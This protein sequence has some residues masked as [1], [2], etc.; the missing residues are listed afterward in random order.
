MDSF[1]NSFIYPFIHSSGGGQE[2]FAP[3]Y[4][5][6]HSF[7]WITFSGRSEEE[8]LAHL[9]SVREAAKRGG[10][11]WAH[12]RACFLLGRLC[13]R[14]LKYSQVRVDFPSFLRVCCQCQR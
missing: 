2:D 6:Q 8:L 1:I 12:R 3:L 11:R 9:E 14:K 4:D 5:L 13:A 10:R 7:L